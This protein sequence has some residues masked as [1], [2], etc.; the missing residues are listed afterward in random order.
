[1]ASE[2]KSLDADFVSSRLP[3]L[4]NLADDIMSQMASLSVQEISTILGISNQLASKARLLAYNFPHKQTG[5]E[6]LYAFIGEAYKGLDVKS[7]SDSAIKNACLNLRIFSSVYGILKPDDIIK[8][9]RCE[10]NKPFLEGNKTPIQILKPK[11]TI[12]IVNQIKERKI[13][14]VINL[15]PGDAEKM[16]DWKIIRAF[17]N[18]NKIVFQT[19]D[20]AGNLKTPIAKRLKELRGIMARTIFELGIE[21]FEDLT[22]VESEHFAYYPEASKPLLPIFIASE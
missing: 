8:P 3:A 16:A 2:Q 17:A 22:K 6:A 12:D 11:V 14:D 13:K 5:L 19:I 15:L 18:V 9:Y 4:E 10:F 7:M 1:M 20:S 21:S